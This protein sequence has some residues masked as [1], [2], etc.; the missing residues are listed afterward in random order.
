L[1]DL[2]SDLN[3]RSTAIANELHT[4]VNDEYAAFLS[5][6]AA[7]Q[8]G[9]EQCQEIKVGLLGFEKGVSGV[10]TSVIERRKEV[11]QLLK[12]REE[13][14]S[15]IATG[16]AIIALSERVE[17]LEQALEDADWD[18]EDEEETDDND[19]DGALV[20]IVA[21]LKSLVMAYVGIT[22]QLERLKAELN[23]TLLASINDRLKHIRETLLIDLSTA[24]TQAT[25]SNTKSQTRLLMVLRL[26]GDLDATEVALK[27]V[28]LAKTKT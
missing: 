12:Q 27:A 7:L 18:S 23:T 16:R 2:R 14:H 1:A 4:L 5:L 26:Y 21:R 3:T 25:S 13:L 9:E 8:G 10:Q 22:K 24:L 15:Q 20:G 19:D 28:K 6:G 11:E 17:D